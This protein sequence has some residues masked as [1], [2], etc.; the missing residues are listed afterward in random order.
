MVRATGRKTNPPTEPRRRLV[1]RR[2]DFWATPTIEELAREQGIKPLT[3]EK[4]E[5]AAAFWPD[6]LDP[7]DFLAIIR[8]ERRRG[9]DESA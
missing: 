9:R 6:D 2:R 3:R 1:G 4:L 7:D 8:E 5:E